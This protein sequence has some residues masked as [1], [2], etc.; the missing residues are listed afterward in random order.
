LSHWY[1][2]HFLAIPFLI[3]FSTTPLYHIYA[4]LSI[5]DFSLQKINDQRQNHHRRHMGYAKTHQR[6]Q[7]AHQ[8][9]RAPAKKK[10]GG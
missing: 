8:N 5:L 3:Y 1:N 4:I 9:T 10:T 6:T 2:L 7:D